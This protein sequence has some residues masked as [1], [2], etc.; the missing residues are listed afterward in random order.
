MQLQRDLMVQIDEPTK[1]QVSER[2]MR[3]YSDI[4]SGIERMQEL[5]EQLKK[6]RIDGRLSVEISDIKWELNKYR[7]FQSDCSWQR[8]NKTLAKVV[9]ALDMLYSQ[10]IR[11]DEYTVHDLLYIAS[12]LQTNI[13]VL[14]QYLTCEGY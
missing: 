1:R 7:I 11:K 5:Y 14:E 2:Q 3:I 10:L 12:T 13:Q 4:G 8:E 6:I 9:A